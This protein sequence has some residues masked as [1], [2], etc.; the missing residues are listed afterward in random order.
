M[1]NLCFSVSKTDFKKK[2]VAWSEKWISTINLLPLPSRS[3]W[4]SL[5]VRFSSEIP[6]HSGWLMTVYLVFV[7]K[8]FFASETIFCQIL[9]WSSAPLPKGNWKSLAEEWNHISIGIDSKVPWQ[10][11]KSNYDWA[12]PLLRHQR[13]LSRSWINSVSVI[14]L[15]CQSHEVR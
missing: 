5:K 4:R 11:F 14:K 12:D 2:C 7:L 1:Q 8:A 13:R 3:P 15:N 10:T 6:I 9:E